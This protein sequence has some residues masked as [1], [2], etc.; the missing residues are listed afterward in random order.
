MCWPLSIENSGPPGPE[1]HN[2]KI[3]HHRLWKMFESAEDLMSDEYLKA[4]FSAVQLGRF[5]ELTIVNR[6]SANV[7]V[8][9]SAACSASIYSTTR[10]PRPRAKYGML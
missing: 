1:L 8:T 2:F 9:P 3:F 5:W 7:I 10:I 4:R 6:Y